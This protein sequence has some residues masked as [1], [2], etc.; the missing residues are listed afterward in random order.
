M[1]MK[2][3]SVVKVEDTQKCYCDDLEFQMTNDEE[4]VQIKVHYLIVLIR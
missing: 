3:E 1:S 2:V 4:A